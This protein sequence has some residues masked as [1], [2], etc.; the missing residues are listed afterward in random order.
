MLK[1]WVQ[2]LGVYFLGSNDPGFRSP[3]AI[4]GASRVHPGSTRGDQG[5]QGA[6]RVHPGAIQGPSR[7]HPG[8]IQG[9]HKMAPGNGPLTQGPFQG[10]PRGL[11]GG[12]QNGIWNYPLARGYTKMPPGSG[13]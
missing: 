7:V 13:P 1:P 2:G 6:T 8:S 9:P 11:P 10:P 3:G 5:P 4:Q 12:T